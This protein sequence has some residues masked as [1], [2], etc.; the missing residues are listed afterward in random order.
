M[1]SLKSWPMSCLLTGTLLAAGCSMLGMGKGGPERVALEV[2]PSQPAAQGTVNIGA[3]KDGNR[4]VEVRVQHLSPPERAT[5]GARTYVVWLVPRSGGAP[6]NMGV[7][8]LGDDLGGSL[9]TTTSYRDF[10]ILVTAEEN[11]GATTPSARNV[12]HASVKLTGHAVR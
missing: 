12:M 10:D 7:L 9:T 3:E 8:N 2:T 1:K 5:P 4:I 11:P 6:Q